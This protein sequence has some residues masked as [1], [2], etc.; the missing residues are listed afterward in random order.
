MANLSQNEENKAEIVRQGVLPHFIQR[1]RT[2][3]QDMQIL[4]ATVRS[5]KLISIPYVTEFSMF[6]LCN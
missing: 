5:K 3:T 6:V 2:R 4:A 1:A